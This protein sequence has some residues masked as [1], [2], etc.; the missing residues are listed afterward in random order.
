MAKG[1]EA[2]AGSE[3]RNIASY[4]S[5]PDLENDRT[6]KLQGLCISIFKGARLGGATSVIYAPLSELMWLKGAEWWA[7]LTN[8]V[9]ATAFLTTAQRPFTAI[10]QGIIPWKH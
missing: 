7:T 6:I 8:A 3:E 2:L 9:S 4:R 1:D 5:P 10:V